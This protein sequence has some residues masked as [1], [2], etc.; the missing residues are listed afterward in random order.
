MIT[1]R[2]VKADGEPWGEC[3]IDGVNLPRGRSLVNKNGQFHIEGL[4]PNQAYDLRILSNG[5]RL[6][7]FIAKGLRVGPGETI[8]LHDIVPQDQ[9]KE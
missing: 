4:I 2:V 1:G 8:D 7:G 3:E 9:G 5:S 6:E